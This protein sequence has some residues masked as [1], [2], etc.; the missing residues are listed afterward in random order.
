GGMPIF[1]DQVFGYNGPLNLGGILVGTDKDLIA[2]G[3][4]DLVIA[5][6]YYQSYD[7]LKTVPDSAKSGVGFH[8]ALYK[9]FLQVNDAVYECDEGAMIQRMPFKPISLRLSPTAVIQQF[10]AS[11]FAAID[12]RNPYGITVLFDEAADEFVWYSTE[13]GHC[14]GLVAANNF[15]HQLKW[16]LLYLEH[17]RYGGGQYTA[18]LKEDS[19]GTLYFTR[20]TAYDQ[21]EFSQVDKQSSLYIADRM[22]LDPNTGGF[23]FSVDKDVFTY[24]DG[25]AQRVHAFED[26]ITMLKFNRFVML[27]EFVTGATVNKD[28][29]QQYEN[30][31]LIATHNPAQPED[32]GK[33]LLFDLERKSVSQ[34][35]DGFSKIID[36]TYKER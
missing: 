11:K 20:F 21:L 18:L 19:T 7:A 4:V 8:G 23:Y 31:L 22:A 26:E 28:R 2:Y 14:S 5:E 24:E 9:Q 15:D 33:L 17:S 16:T 36:V 25:V 1:I 3:S 32:S 30:H 35:F 10:P 29:Y 13:I 27:I 34:Q 6:A 12:I